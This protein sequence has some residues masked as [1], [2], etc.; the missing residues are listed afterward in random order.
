ML[1]RFKKL[2]AESSIFLLRSPEKNKSDIGGSGG[3]TRGSLGRAAGGVMRRAGA[4]GEVLRSGE[5]SGDG[6]AGG[7]S[8]VPGGS[9]KGPPRACGLVGSEFRRARVSDRRTLLEDVARVVDTRVHAT[10][11]SD[12]TGI[13]HGEL[14]GV[15]HEVETRGQWRRQFAPV[16]LTVSAVEA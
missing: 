4:S 6:E 11:G 16:A 14:L 1:R 7:V 3:G 5:V 10:R 9:G 2:A 15:L 12:Y 13:L 8:A